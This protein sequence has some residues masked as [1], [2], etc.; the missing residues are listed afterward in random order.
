MI[1]PISRII[2]R[3]VSGAMVAYG[4]VPQDV[5]AEIAV[6][7]DL[8]ALLGLALGASTEIAYAFAVKRGWAK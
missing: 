5:G 6:D 2:L 8:L 3:Y 1:G 4:L 7:P